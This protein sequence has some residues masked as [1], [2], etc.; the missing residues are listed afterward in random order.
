MATPWSS[1]DV[2]TG[3]TF[4]NPAGAAAAGATAYTRALLEVLGD[5]DP[6][7]VL[8]QLLPWLTP[9]IA[10]LDDTTLRRPEAPGQWSVIEVV[11][12][13]ADSD[14]VFGY[15][16]RMIVTED[17]PTVSAGPKAS[18]FYCGSW[19]RTTWYT[20][21]RSVASSMFEFQLQRTEGLARAGVLTLPHGQVQTPGFMPVGTHGVVRG[22]SAGDVR[23]T[24]AQIILGNTYHLHLRPG[25]EVIRQMGGLNRFTTW[26]RPI[27]TDSGG[28]QVFSLHG[29]R[30]IS[31][32]GVEFQSHIDGTSRVLT[33]ERA[34]EIQW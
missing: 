7:E 5:R 15:R 31:E 4:S 10:G 25:E 24:G 32:N 1:C 3:M 14:L 19:R 16:L 6:L 34:M 27:L 30:R 29:L 12:H 13:L 20:G 18:V 21:G 9:R 28:F 8:G 17:H 22:L 26:D 2:A 23:R 11:Q 33:P